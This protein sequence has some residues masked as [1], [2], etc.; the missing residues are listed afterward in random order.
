MF[1]CLPAS[2]QLHNLLIEELPRL[3][4][5]GRTLL[6]IGRPLGNL[7]LARFCGRVRINPLEDVAVALAKR[8]LLPKMLWI[9]AGKAK[10][11]LVE[12]TRILIGSIDAG[13]SGATFVEHSRKED[14]ATEPHTRAARRALRQIRCIAKHDKE[15]FFTGR[16]VG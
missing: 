10:E 7:P 15:V 6:D 2:A 16:V 9:N 4:V 5:S 11:A 3:H 13:Q 12:R 8:Q 1:G 14:I